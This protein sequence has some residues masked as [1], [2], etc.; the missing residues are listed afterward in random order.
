MRKRKDYAQP[1]SG[2]LDNVSQLL[3]SGG[4]GWLFHMNGTV[5]DLRRWRFVGFPSVD[6]DGKPS[7][8]ATNAGRD[9]LV[10]SVKDALW[11]L[12]AKG[13]TEATLANL[14]RAGAT[15]W[16][17]YLDALT[18]RGKMVCAAEQVDRKLVEQYIAWLIKRPARKGSGTIKYTSAKALYGFTKTILK[19]VARLEGLRL[20]IFPVNPFPGADRAY[21][22]ARPFDKEELG[23]VIRAL[24][25]DL[26]AIRNGTW[27]GS[28]VD[29]LTVYFLLIAARTGRNVTPLLEMTVESL[30]PHP[31]RENMGLLKLYKRRGNR[32]QQ[33]GF[34]C[35]QEIS[36][37]GSAP[38][39]VVSLFKEVVVVT[40]ELRSE[41]AAD[42]PS[43]LWMYRDRD[44][45]RVGRL[46]ATTLYLALAASANVME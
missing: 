13:A 11:R 29:T 46:G 37:T 22:G 35:Q 39:D 20:D 26:D 6:D 10:E 27:S 1:T 45:G 19:E 40:A 28:A 2:A 33:L 42:E 17:Q 31:L 32:I 9:S 30:A 41:L 36:H 7:S 3:P 38:K 18:A 25:T 16:F 5:F 8:T 44:T 12:K 43:W 23:T 34:H 21:V 24:G 15:T 14:V 4:A